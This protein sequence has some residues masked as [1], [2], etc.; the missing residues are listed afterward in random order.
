MSVNEQLEQAAS[1]DTS[2]GLLHANELTTLN[3]NLGSGYKRDGP[4]EL[5]SNGGS[6]VPMPALSQNSTSVVATGS[7]LT[8]F[9]HSD[10]SNFNVKTEPSDFAQKI[11]S[12]PL[13]FDVSN[14]RAPADGITEEPLEI[15]CGE[16][17][18]LLYVSKLCQGSKGPCIL[19]QG[20][21]LT[22]NEL[23]YISGRETAK[24]WKR[25]IRYKGKS[26]KSLIARGLIKVHPPICDCLGCRISSPVNRGRLASKCSVSSPP[27]PNR[28]RKDSVKGIWRQDGYATEAGLALAAEARQRSS[29]EAS[30][31]MG[32]SGLRNGVEPR[33]SPAVDSN[34]STASECSEP[35]DDCPFSP[36]TEAKRA[37]SLSPVS[38]AKLVDM[39]RRATD[40]FQFDPRSTYFFR[41]L[42]SEY[43]SPSSSEAG[44]QGRK[45][46]ATVELV[47]N[48]KSQETG[49]IPSVSLGN[50]SAFRAVHQDTSN[51]HEM[52]SENH[53]NPVKASKQQQQQQQQQ[54][55][56]P[57]T[58]FISFT[59]LP[60]PSTLIS[61]THSSP[62]LLP[63]P[64]LLAASP[65]GP[66]MY[67]QALR[68]SLSGVPSASLHQSLMHYRLLTPP[69]PHSPLAQSIPLQ[70]SFIQA[71][72]AAAAAVAR[73]GIQGLPV[74]HSSLSMQRP[75]RPTSPNNTV[76]MNGNIDER[77]PKKAR[78]THERQEVE[79]RGHTKETEA[80]NESCITQISGSDRDCVTRRSPDV[81]TGTIERRSPFAQKES[82]GGTDPPRISPY[83]LVPRFKPDVTENVLKW[84]VD[85]VCQFVSS[86][87]GSPE[88]AHAF[89]EENVDGHSFVLIQEDHLLNRMSI[90]LGPALKIN[91]Q[92]RKLAENLEIDESS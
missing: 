58:S 48:H 88:I 74:S 89:R 85:D 51:S 27:S 82:S 43:V 3:Q 91:A 75:S 65:H 86:L 46:L 38:S 49:E 31:C 92:I 13:P 14:E 44:K 18:A 23:Q 81:S 15:Q 10:Q 28:K 84:S 37:R 19:F 66:S 72:A 56:K 76:A 47:S 53:V 30:N 63:D 6:S 55:Q 32:G 61:P 45:D 29:S 40:R 69:S 39:K 17:A 79:D 71:N 41:D 60:S 5:N 25:S 77:I 34:S 52:S 70:S 1:R 54:Q 78:I 35:T 59:Q 68:G 50:R 11:I 24:D 80:T 90:R 42:P 26:L 20:E 9:T 12:E 83:K 7:P 67:H 73:A 21:W 4:H 57:S 87:T 33:A 16:N 8:A 62:R 2:A 36:G 22:P 64:L